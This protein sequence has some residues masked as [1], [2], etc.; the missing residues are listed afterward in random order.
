MNTPLPKYSAT[1]TDIIFKVYQ[2]RRTNLWNEVNENAPVT[3]NKIFWG[4]TNLTLNFNIDTENYRG[5]GDSVAV[6]MPFGYDFTIEITRFFTN[7]NDTFAHLM[8]QLTQQTMYYPETRSDGAL[9]LISFGIYMQKRT[10]NIDTP[11][12]LTLVLGGRAAITDYNISTEKSRGEERI[13][14]SQYTAISL[15]PDAIPQV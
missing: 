3:V 12:N 15:L 14:L 2:Y 8:T 7:M 4:I 10:G 13:T 1:G 6:R 5:I 9:D 11:T